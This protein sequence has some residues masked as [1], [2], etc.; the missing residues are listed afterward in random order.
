MFLNSVKKILININIFCQ[1]RV[2]QFGQQ[3]IYFAIFGIIGYPLSYI[4]RTYYA[5]LPETENLYLRLVATILCALLL[6]YKKS[7]KAL[8]KYL[9][10]YWYFT[11]MFSIPFFGTY[12]L[13]QNN[14]SMD[15]IINQSIGLFILILLVDW[16]MFIILSL[17]GTPLAFLVFYIINRK[18]N[19]DFSQHEHALGIYLYIWIFICGV[20]FS[21]KKQQFQTDIIQKQNKLNKK[22]TTEI[23]KK[24]QKL[25]ATLDEKKNFLQNFTHELRTP[26][27]SILLLSEQLNT[28]WEKFSKDKTKSIIEMIYS[29]SH[30]LSEMIN[31]I[32]DLSFYVSRKA[33]FTFQNK[34]FENIIMRCIETNKPFLKAS[35]SHLQINLLYNKNE[36]RKVYLDPIKIQQAINNLISNAIK[37]SRPQSKKINIEV[38]HLQDSIL[39]S[40]SDYGIGIPK[41]EEDL[42]F[43]AF[44]RG[45]NSKTHQTGKGLGLPIVKEIIEGH[46]GKVW[47]HKTSKNG[48]TINFT[49]PLKHE[50][51]KT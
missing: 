17:I 20:I 25:L 21:S 12:L 27:H 43:N 15:W 47:V 46:N 51:E 30:N 40:I 13:L 37:Y 2:L 33:I 16:L 32:I 26:L 18:I 3:Y 50:E 9:P 24:S 19:F 1:N 10:L 28:R 48:T 22:L 41:K 42:I 14:M 39:F 4:Y 5:G 29:A 6:F 35:K 45:S 34:N 8:A 23:H 31:N 11:L 44:V 7:P 49:I 38:K 36:P